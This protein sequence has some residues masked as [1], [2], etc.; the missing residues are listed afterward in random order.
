MTQF[1][2]RAGRSGRDRRRSPRRTRA[3]ATP[4]RALPARIRRHGHVPDRSGSLPL[5]PGRPDAAVRIRSVSARRQNTLD[6]RLGSHRLADDRRAGR[7]ARHANQGRRR[8]AI[9]D[10]VDP[11]EER[12]L[13][14]RARGRHRELPTAT[15]QGG[16]ERRRQPHR[17]TPDE[18]HQP[19]HPPRGFD[20]LHRDPAAGER[21]SH[22]DAGRCGVCEVPHR[23]RA[24][25]G[26]A[27][28]RQAVPQLDHLAYQGDG[29]ARHRREACAAG[30]ALPPADAR[31]RRS[32]SACRSCR[33]C[34]ARTPSSVFS[35]RSRSASSSPSSGWTFLAFQRPS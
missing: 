23:R 16:R 6:R 34:T 1:T 22:R 17:R 5:D 26:D 30:R 3:G 24:A 18:R 2:H 35:T 8:P 9:G 29:R 7:V 19:G 27:A 10:R 28:D 21:Y 32:T 14:A 25:G 20:D 12:E 15:A 33:A 4:G 13:A 11:Q 31:G